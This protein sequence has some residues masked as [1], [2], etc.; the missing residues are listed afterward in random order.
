M[1][2]RLQRSQSKFLFTTYVLAY[3][4]NFPV[5]CLSMI[6]PR[7]ILRFF[8]WLPFV[9]S[10][11]SS[12]P[13]PWAARDFS[14]FFQGFCCVFAERSLNC[15]R[16]SAS[17]SFLR[18]V[19][20]ANW[21]WSCKACSDSRALFELSLP[22]SDSLPFL[23]LDST[24]TRA[25]L[26]LSSGLAGLLQH[27]HAWGGSW[28]DPGT[29]PAKRYSKASIDITSDPKRCPTRGIHSFQSRLSMF[30]LI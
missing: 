25:R 15:S 13:K 18:S 27:C 20:W 7:S 19:S 17:E 16:N 26:R 4:K 24:G 23:L 28:V 11:Q 9:A 2:C 8:T 3:L 5:D 12:E 10:C 6:H 14:N 21:L 1:A 22:A 30:F 29:G